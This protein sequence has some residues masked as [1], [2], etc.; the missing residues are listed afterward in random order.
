MSKRRRILVNRGMELNEKRLQG[1]E[2]DVHFRI[3]D[4]EFPAHKLIVGLKSPYLKVLVSPPP[5]FKETA[6]KIDLSSDISSQAFSVLLDY[7]YSGEIY[8]NEENIFEIIETASYLQINDHLMENAKEFLLDMISSVS[9]IKIF[10]QIWNIAERFS[11]SSLSDK[12][13]KVLEHRLEDFLSQDIFSHIGLEELSRL[14]SNSSLCF[15]DEQQLWNTLV[16]LNHGEED[17]EICKRF[18]DIL[19]QY[20]RF[21]LISWESHYLTESAINRFQLESTSQSDDKSDL[22]SRTCHNCV[23]IFEYTKGQNSLQNIE[24]F[25]E[26]KKFGPSFAYVSINKESP[27]LHILPSLTNGKSYHQHYGPHSQHNYSLL[28]SQSSLF[29]LGGL[30]THVSS[31]TVKSSALSS[32]LKTFEYSSGTWLRWRSSIPTPSVGFGCVFA[33]GKVYILGGLVE[34]SNSSSIKGVRY[35]NSKLGVSRKVYVA[36]EGDLTQMSNSCWEQLCDMPH[37]RTDFATVHTQNR[38]YLIACCGFN[39]IIH[40]HSLGEI[41]AIFL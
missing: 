39:W 20:F 14:L 41:P 36:M 17:E 1:V 19:A 16:P 32:D 27:S 4:E 29:I 22:P 8:L 21:N 31:K 15:R 38:I 23:Y 12:L 11:L 7:I 34:D 10:L 25:L 2:V 30:T 18:S 6:S 37:E 9:D 28:T 3:E 24:S 35:L 5:G 33:A 13:Y 26:D 40:I